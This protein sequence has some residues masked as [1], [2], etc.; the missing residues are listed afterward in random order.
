[1][2]PSRIDPA[3]YETV[4][5]RDIITDPRFNR[6]I[7]DQWVARLVADFDVARLGRIALSRRDD[8]TLVI[9]DGQHRCRALRDKGVP[10]DAK[11]IPADVYEGLGRSAEALLFVHLNQT[12]HVSSL[13][14]YRALLVAADPET[15]GIDSVVR[16]QGLIVNSGGKDGSIGCIDALRRLYN[17]GEPSGAVLGRTLAT[18]HEAWGDTHEAYGS[19]L[20]RGVGLFLN[21][22]R[23]TDP[24][25][26]ANALV[27][28]PGA[29]INLIGWAKAIAG[30]HRM[31]M[32]KAIAQIIEQRV[33]KRRARPRKVSTG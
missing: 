20:V 28:G 21:D 7:S 3:R 5:L 30:T 29:P 9:L 8:G 6:P 14:K 17:M 4:R 19:Q 24:R 22:Y 15:R 33:V 32:D 13:E 12:K 23:E 27:R 25:E 26:L 31:A 11:V 2:T 10:D 18:L 1:M 16:A